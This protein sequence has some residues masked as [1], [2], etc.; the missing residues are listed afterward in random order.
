MGWSTTGMAAQYQHVTDPIRQ[1]VASASGAPVGRFGAQMRPELRPWTRRRF[2]A[3][4]A[5][6]VWPGQGGGGGVQLTKAYDSG[7]WAF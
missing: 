5:L 7:S 4:S 2:R 1:E 6:S 3:A